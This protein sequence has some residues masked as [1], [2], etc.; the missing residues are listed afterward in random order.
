MHARDTSRVNGGSVWAVSSRTFP[1][2][3]GAVTRSRC[4]DRTEPSGDGRGLWIV[5]GRSSLPV[6]H[7]VDEY[8]RHGIA[9]DRLRLVPLFPTGVANDLNS[10]LPRPRSNRI[11]FVGRVTQLKG[12]SH[13]QAALPIACEVL[14]RQLTLVVAGSGPDLMTAETESRRSGVPTEFIGWVGPERREAEMRTADVLAVPSVWPEP[15]GLVGIEAG[16]VGLPAVAYAV[17]GIPDW[18]VPGVSG[19][20]APGDK[21]DPKLFATALIRAL[22]DDDHLQRLRVGAWE[23]SRQFTPEAHLDLLLRILEAATR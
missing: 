19:E 14:G 9:E 12:L 21:P 18:L 16:C 7:M 6:E 15:F 10:P 8:R 5:T 4:S 13:L 23:M 1:A 20:S 11:L 3:A 2:G 17:G 22:A